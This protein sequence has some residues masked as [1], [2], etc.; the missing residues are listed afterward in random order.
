MA[1]EKEPFDWF[2]KVPASWRPF[3]IVV[4]IFWVGIIG[5]CIATSGESTAEKEV[6]LAQEAAETAQQE[7]AEQS[8][9]AERAAKIER[10]RKETCT[11]KAEAVFT[12]FIGDRLGSG[13]LVEPFVWKR[14][15]YTERVGFSGWI[16]LCLFDGEMAH[17]KHAMTGEIMGTWSID[18]GYQP[19]DEP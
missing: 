8:A 15:R 13:V 6:R 11:P 12:P 18:F 4:A 1:A 5:T 17:V 2:G 7:V 19:G 3:Q 10:L 9:A 14:L 16:S